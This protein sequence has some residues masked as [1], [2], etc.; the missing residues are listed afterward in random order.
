[1]SPCLY[2]TPRWNFATI[3]DVDDHNWTGGVIVSSHQK[4]WWYF[5]KFV[6]TD[7]Q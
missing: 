6:T 1:M 5:S 7:W 4:A 2:L 3:F